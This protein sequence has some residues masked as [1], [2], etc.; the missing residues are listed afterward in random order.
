MKTMVCLVSAQHVPNFLPIKTLEPDQVVMVVTKETRKNKNAESL[1]KALEVR[2]GV[3]PEILE[4][5]FLTDEKSIDAIKCDLKPSLLKIIEK[6]KAKGQETE[7][8]VNLTGSTKLI[9][10]AAYDSFLNLEF[11]NAKYLYVDAANPGLIF[12]Q[13]PWAITECHY[14][15]NIEEFFV[16]YGE[17][18]GNKK[19]LDAKLTFN[20]KMEVLAREMAET[21]G[22][23]MEIK[24][25]NKNKESW[26]KNIRK[27]GADLK[28]GE[29]QLREDFGPKIAAELDLI[30][31]NG[32]LK[33]KVD[34]NV[35]EFLTGG[36]LETFITNWIIKHQEKCG[37]SE[38]LP[39]RKLVV[40]DHEFDVCFIKGPILH[41]IECKTG[42]GNKNKETGDLFKIFTAVKEL[43]A[44]KT[45]IWLVS[46]SSNIGQIRDRAKIL[47]IKLMD[48]KIVS[49]IAKHYDEPSLLL[50]HL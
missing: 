41:V 38:V 5:I 25:N 32:F 45:K 28:D 21:G 43:G 23:L 36:W 30:F 34:T 22:D 33:G 37:V 48:R 19:N 12:W 3:K 44:I 39:G 16:G 14:K 27:N 40:E 18:I 46:T 20:E 35:G 6:N 24:V 8:L 50:K 11:G 47:G 13:N 9:S 2:A 4:D 49:E 7:W 29:V 26:I 17:E 10:I 42:T 15:M 31:E 1:K